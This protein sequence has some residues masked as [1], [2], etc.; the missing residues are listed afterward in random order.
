MHCVALLLVYGSGFS[1]VSVFLGL[2]LS[3]HF[4]ASWGMVMMIMMMMVGYERWFMR[5]GKG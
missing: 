1:F 5:H 3:V 2:S 4:G